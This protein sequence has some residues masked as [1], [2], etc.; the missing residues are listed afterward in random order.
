MSVALQTDKTPA[1]YA[2]LGA[3]VE[4]L[5][6][7][8]LSV[9]ADLGYQPPLPA[10]LAVAGATRRI[11]L[12]VA[13]WS[14][15]LLHPVEI[16]GQLAALH[17]AAPGRAY[18]G[19]VRGSWLDRIG[20]ATDRPVRRLAEC[21]GVLT[22]LLGGDDQGYH[23]EIYTLAPGFRLAYPLPDR[24]PPLLVGTWSPT[25]ARL[26][27]LHADEVK[28]GGCTNPDMVALMH[29]WLT[30]AAAAAG[31]PDAP[32]VV[33]GAVTVVDL[34]RG[35]ALRRARREVAMYLDVVAELDRTLEVDPDLLARLRSRLRDGDADGAGAVIDTDLLRRFAF[36]GTPAD[37]VEQCTALAAAGAGRIEFGTPH[38]L[39]D[40]GGIELLGRAVLPAL[41]S[42]A[43]DAR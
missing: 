35:A 11:R 25:T 15:A 19:L 14:P 36:A 10:L 16:A 40:D 38:G 22:R 34:D 26:A 8:G 4:T 3:A 31:R 21:I 20:V 6:F 1:A 29:S 28:L 37:I 9:F 43:G 5:G 39:T 42:T 18:L 24:M 32:G 2:R 41:R 17:D 23:G 30:G 7:D 27:A 33:A 12:G 13:G